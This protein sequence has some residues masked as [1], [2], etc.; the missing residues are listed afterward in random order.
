MGG[1]TMLRILAGLAL[2][3]W[4]VPASADDKFPERP[5]RLVVPLAAGGNI[6]VMAR[7]LA[8]RLSQ[9]LGQ[10]VIVENLVG[11]G[12]A[13]GARAVA[14]A[15]PDGY[16]LLF[17]GPAQAQLPYVYKTLPYDGIN[18][19][20]GVSLVGEYPL[21]IVVNPKVPAKTLP[22]FVKLL[23]ENPGKY[24]YGSSGVGG[25]S[26]LAAELFTSLA[27]VKMVHVPFRGNQ[28]AMVALLGGQIEMLIDGM[29]AQQ[30]HVE[31]GTVNVLGVTSR[32]RSPFF[33]S[34]T[35]VAD[36]LPGY[37]FPLWLAVF[38]PANTPAPV[39]AKLSAEIATAT[40]EPGVRK[41]FTDMLTEPKSSTPAE[42]T[43]FFKD[44]LRFNQELVSRA[45]IAPIE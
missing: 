15:K 29:A 32:G 21:V 38:A 30:K 25:A 35:P 4:A 37:E 33:P 6:D 40:R 12:G 2:L 18:A 19:F 10:N 23:K 8:E 22:E 24:N 28:P 16:T 5:I 20:T 1:L 27:D 11:A 17:Q 9:Q 45:K 3:L 14:E 31:A 42:T 34:V 43:A 13:I 41:R 39:V 26:H 44:Q 36:T 7:I